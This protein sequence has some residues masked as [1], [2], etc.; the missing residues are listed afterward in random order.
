MKSPKSRTR[1]SVLADPVFA[2]SAVRD[3]IRRAPPHMPYSELAEL[4]RREFGEARAWPAERIR[5]YWLAVTPTAKGRSR[6]YS[7]PAV[8]AFLDDRIG[9]M[10]IRELTA[11][12]AATFGP[13]LAPSHSAIG[14]YV[15]AARNGV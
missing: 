2:D 6:I 10:T 8:Q 12:C 9:R 15:K 5:R 11:A 7:N 14:R 3:F 13:G 1:S 4:L